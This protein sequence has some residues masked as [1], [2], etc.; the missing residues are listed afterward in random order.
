MFLSHSSAPELV[1]LLSELNDAIEQL[2]R[3]VNPLL[4]LV[5]SVL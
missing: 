4:S 2:E 5:F 3:K 1:G